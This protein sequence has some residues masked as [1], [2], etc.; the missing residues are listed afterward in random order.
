MPLKA[1]ASGRPAIAFAVGSAFETIANG[2]SGILC[3]E[4]SRPAIVEAIEHCSRVAWNPAE[5]A[6]YARDFDVSVFRARFI[7]VLEDILGTR[8]TIGAVA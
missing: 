4:P 6:A 1:N 5:L 7:A 8:S 2:E 3:W